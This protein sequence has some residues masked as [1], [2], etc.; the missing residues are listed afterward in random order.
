MTVFGLTGNIGSG[1]STVGKI[2]SEYGFLHIDAD[3]VGHLVVEPGM[4]ANIKIKEIFGKE[5]FDDLGNLNRKKLG[6]YV[7]SNKEAL[8]KLNDITHPAIKDYIVKQ[9]EYIQKTQPNKHIIVEAALLFEAGMQK[10]V[11]KV[12]VVIAEDSKRLSR[13]VARDNL[14]EDLIKDRMKNQIDQEIKKQLA[15]Y[16]IENNGDVSELTNN[17]VLFLESLKI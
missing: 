4:P 8:Q 5:Y 10:L 2:L 12:I 11:D 15:D 16:V 14:A 7:F 3:R 1:K 13:V 17:I 9:I 6:S